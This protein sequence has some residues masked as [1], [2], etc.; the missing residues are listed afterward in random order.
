MN[1]ERFEEV[2]RYL[3]M[4][5][6]SLRNV[7]KHIASN[8]TE[9]RIRVNRP[10]SVETPFERY[11]CGSECVTAEKIKECMKRFCDYSVYSCERELSEGW[12]TLKGG[13][14]AGFAGT[15]NI[16]GKNLKTIRDFSSI[17]V[18]I[19]REHKGMADTIFRRTAFQHDFRGLLVLGPPL[20]AKTTFLRDYCRLL[21][22]FRK[23]SVIDERSEIAAVY[24]GI[25]QNDIGINADVLD[26]F[27]K[28]S[29][30]MI[31]LR[32]LSPEYIVCDEIGSEVKELIT[33]FNN[34]VRLILSAHCS[35]LYEA[36][37]NVNIT[38][39]VNSGAISHIILLDSGRN[40]GK[41]KGLWRIDNAEDMS[42][43]GSDN[44][45]YGC[46]NAVFA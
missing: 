16:N 28:V 15:A 42:F 32:S 35:S 12:I 29:G 22:A 3:Y 8:A 20:S 27:D 2:K 23:V 46:R 30:I 43:C 39:I 11:I 13:H 1:D 44:N 17:N 24:N 21:S 9:I 19:S 14:R 7:P 25:P 18:R 37:R 36:G 38:E 5:E 10:V 26:C 45:L 31:A 6:S 33:C 4:F 34:G 40:I 41:I